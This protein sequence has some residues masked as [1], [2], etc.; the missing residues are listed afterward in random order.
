[1]VR[2][3]TRLLC[4]CVVVVQKFMQSRTLVT[5]L[6]MSRMKDLRL[7]VVFIQLQVIIYL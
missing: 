3:I 5:A 6:S 4:G 1:M 2:G 7:V